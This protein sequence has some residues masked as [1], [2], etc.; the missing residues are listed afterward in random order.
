MRDVFVTFVVLGS[1]PFI[2]AR[3]YVGVLMWAWLGFMN[4][5]RLAWGFAVNLPF[6]QVIAITTLFAM[7]FSQERKRIPWTRETFVLL[8]FI[9]WMLITTFFAFN[10]IGA[11]QQ[12]DKVWKI[13]L[14]V[15]VTLIL[16]QRIERLQ[17]LI[18]VIVLSL[19]FY[20][21]KGGIFTITTGGNYRVYGPQESFIG[22]NNEIALALIMVIPLMRYLQLTSERWWVKKGMTAAMGLSTV[23]IL[24]THSRG[25]LIGIA[26]MF[27]FLILKSR[28]RFTFACVLALVIPLGL[29]IMPQKWFDRMQSISNYEQDASAQG[30]INAWR[31]AYNL[32]QDRPI[33]GGG[34][35]TFRPEL[36]AVYAPVPEDPHDAHSIYFEVLGEHGFVGLFLFVSLGLVAWLSCSQLFKLARGHPELVGLSDL[37]RMVQVSLVGYAA[38]GAF[39]GLAYFDLY[40]NLVGIV[41]LAKILAHDHIE[42]IAG[43]LESGRPPAD[44]P[45]TNPE[46]AVVK[47]YS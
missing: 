21:V 31:F 11:W 9:V 7:L 15:F 35:E 1:I 37:G 27:L 23:S 39:L 41:I 13:Q 26:A 19:G 33:V 43:E 8:L 34:F 20:G 44:L 2:L 17:A 10:Q 30:R 24:G 32:A 29:L 25:A 46:D 6:A 4:P 40:Y 3:P 16:M 42:M 38:G 36:F 18:W 5:H 28:K 45:V 14:M 22:G 12:W 47:G